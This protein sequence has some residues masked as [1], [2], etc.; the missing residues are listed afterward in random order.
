[1]KKRLGRVRRL[2]ISTPV[3][4]PFFDPKVAPTLVLLMYGRVNRWAH[5][6]ILRDSPASTLVRI[7][8]EVNDFAT[9]AGA[10]QAGPFIDVAIL[11]QCKLCI[12]E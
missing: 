3:Y 11:N 6:E 12:I 5:P 7:Q 4:L 9:T 1:M 10:F 8:R 2:P